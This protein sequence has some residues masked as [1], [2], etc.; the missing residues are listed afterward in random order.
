MQVLICTYGEDGI[1]RV[2]AI[3]H[4]RVV[5]VTWLVSWQVSDN[6]PVPDVLVRSDFKIVR[7]NSK[8]LSRNRNIALQNATDDIVLISDDDI[9]YT[10]EQL[11]RII[12]IFEFNPTLDIVT[13]QHLPAMAQ[14]AKIYPECCFD[15]NHK[16]KGY[17]LTSFELAFRLKSQQRVN[18]W[19]DER[20]GIGG[21]LFSTEEEGL[22]LHEL[23]SKGLKGKFFA[24]NLCKHIGGPTSANKPELQL[25][26]IEA[27][28]AY[29]KIVHPAT[30]LLRMILYAIKQDNISKI[31]FIKAWIKG[32]KLLKK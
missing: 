22:F 4:P 25:K 9:V 14:Y 18:V 5:G 10:S 27:N 21:S 17:Y 23:L 19:F 8:G 28:A 13:F 32:V 12:Q 11:K 2:A 15:L 16:K 31:K 6:V 24:E 1:S 30:S 3:D 7:S 20:F 26:R 29:H